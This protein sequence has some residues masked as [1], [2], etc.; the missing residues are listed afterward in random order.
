MNLNMRPMEAD[1]IHA[2]SEK[3]L[4]RIVRG[5]DKGRTFGTP[6]N[7]R[8]PTIKEFNPRIAEISV[9]E[10]VRSVVA[11]RHGIV[12]EQ[13]NEIRRMTNEE[14]VMFRSDDPMSAAEVQGG[15]SLTGG[16]HRLHEMKDRISSHSL[17]EGGIIRVL[18]HD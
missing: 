3:V 14:L 4:F 13:L 12:P 2:L 6:R 9:S 11:I 17:D 18:I 7:P 16:H 10:F 1:A 15:L 8:S 5:D